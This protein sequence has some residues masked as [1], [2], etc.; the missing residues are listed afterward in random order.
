[1]ETRKRDAVADG[2]RAVVDVH[3]EV[4]DARDRE[5]VLREVQR[6]PASVAGSGAGH[7]HR[8]VAGAG[9][10]GGDADRC[11][12]GVVGR[13]P[14]LRV[15]RGDDDGLRLRRG[16]RDAEHQDEQRNCLDSLH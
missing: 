5:R 10:R 8:S 14:S 6:E 7:L 12:A 3:A 4:R 2:R 15:A 9:M 1:M 11:C 13:R 16:C